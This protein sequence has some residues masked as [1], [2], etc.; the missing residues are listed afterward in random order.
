M[1]SLFFGFRK[2]PF[3]LIAQPNFD[4]LST[5]HQLILNQLVKNLDKTT[6]ISLLLGAAGVG[7][8]TLIKR[9]VTDYENQNRDLIF[10]DLSAGTSDQ[11]SLATQENSAIFL[12]SASARDLSNSGKPH[13]K[14]VFLL[15]HTDCVNDDFLEECLWVVTERNATKK[16]TLLI[17]I[18][19]PHLESRLKSPRFISY[20][21][22]LVETNILGCL[23]QGEVRDY[24]L[25]RLRFA[26]YSGKTLFDEGAIQCIAKFS[27]GI[28]RVINIL[29]GNCLFQ[30]SL[31]QHHVITEEIVN[32]AAEFCLLEKDVLK[33]E[34]SVKISP[35]TPSY[36]LSDKISVLPGELI[37]QLLQQVVQIQDEFGQNRKA[38]KP[39]PDILSE[40]IL[41]QQSTA[42]TQPKAVKSVVSKIQN[43]NSTIRES[44][45]AVDSSISP[46]RPLV[47]ALVP[48]ETT[49]FKP[50][51]RSNRNSDRAISNHATPEGNHIGFF[52]KLGFIVA[53]VLL[54]MAAIFW[55]MEQQSTNFSGHDSTDMDGKVKTKKQDELKLLR[56]TEK[57]QKETGLVSNT[58]ENQPSAEIKTE[59]I[60][61]NASIKR[62]EQSDQKINPK[63]T[64]AADAILE[65]KTDT[66]R[67]QNVEYPDK[68]P[69]RIYI[70]ALLAKARKHEDNNQLTRPVSNNA[71]ET[72]RR[73]LKINPGNADATRG[74]QRIK[75]IFIY[76]AKSFINQKQWQQA[77]AAAVK[78]LQID[79]GDIP[80]ANL[81]ADI[82]QHK[83]PAGGIT[84]N[85]AQEALDLPVSND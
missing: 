84:I 4:Y 31:N 27:K 36:Q 17:L 69:I 21:S 58:I 55:I 79:P 81:L 82:R 68:D 7:K 19:L 46:I 30:A 18:G 65:T 70:A 66:L 20:K 11:L 67:T 52:N 5:G 45:Q 71:V 49:E 37:T 62:I 60:N 32:S 29:C 76:Q 73:I 54:S 26:E 64:K 13:A 77:D 85:E 6:G 41:E 47:N 39:P 35:P 48:S 15:D 44:K 33:A 72:F 22:L 59:R 43:S 75:Q 2:N 38:I 14:T 1:Y 16:P 23:D 10:K 63:I 57:S 80:V 56:R 25:H 78:A 42:E 83:K 8:S 9:M 24:I 28:P 61:S 34:K 53:T 12:E 3:G 51:L 40:P 74:I 50:I